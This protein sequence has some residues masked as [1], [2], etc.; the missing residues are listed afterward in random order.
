[1]ISNLS[2]HPRTRRPLCSR[3]QKPL[4]TCLCSW[5]R[6]TPNQIAVLVL[7]HPAETHHAKGSV[8]LLALS[9]DECRCVVGERFDPLQLRDW[10]GQDTALLYPQDPAATP[11]PPAAEAAAA[12]SAEAATESA[13]PVSRLVVLDGT[14]RQSR[15]LLR[16]NPWLQ[17][18]QRVGLRGPPP[19]Q[20]V[21]RQRHRPDQRSTLEATC[22]ALGELEAQPA[23]YAP[24]LSAFEGWVHA[25]QAQQAAGTGASGRTPGST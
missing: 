10:Q 1:M 6:P 22:L 18:L 21:I 2:T 19:S 13:P 17:R 11:A 3:C 8:G 20:Y 7:Q 15:L 5:I 24:L 4:R 12:P 9:L 25:L 14:W 16:L 23:R